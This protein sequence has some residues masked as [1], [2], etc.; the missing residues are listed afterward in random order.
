MI[1]HPRLNFAVIATE[2]KIK[3]AEWQPSWLYSIH[4]KGGSR[5]MDLRPKQPKAWCPPVSRNHEM[6]ILEN[7]SSR[8]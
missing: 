2:A 4:H 5:D 3:G 7:H 6:L 8:P 1:S